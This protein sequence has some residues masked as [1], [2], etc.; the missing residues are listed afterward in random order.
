[1]PFPSGGRLG[2]STREH[3]V[4]RNIKSGDRKERLVSSAKIASLE[5]AWWDKS[6]HPGTA[7]PSTKHS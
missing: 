2:C 7:S 1:M 6:L 3:G 5:L 4:T